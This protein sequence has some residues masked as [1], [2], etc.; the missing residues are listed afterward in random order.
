[1]VTGSE[2]CLELDCL[3][4]SWEVFRAFAPRILRRLRDLLVDFKVGKEAFSSLEDLTRL[5]GFHGGRRRREPS[6]GRCRRRFV[7]EETKD[8]SQRE[9]GTRKF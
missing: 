4:T 7:D 1:M 9:V 8:D 2:E 6:F 5:N 3:E